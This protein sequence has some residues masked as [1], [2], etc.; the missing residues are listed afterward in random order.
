MKQTRERT[1]RGLVSA[2]LIL[3]LLVAGLARAQAVGSRATPAQL[4]QARAYIGRSWHTLTRSNRDLA[5]AAVD[6]KFKPD[7]SNRNPAPAGAYRWPVYVARDEDLKGIERSLR[8]Q[9]RPE[10]FAR[11]ELRQLPARPNDAG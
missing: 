9:M 5:A 1:L 11:I 10:E 2:P 6:P 3:V 4:E 8:E 7:D